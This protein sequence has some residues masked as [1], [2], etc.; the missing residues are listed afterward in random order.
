VHLRPPPALLLVVAHPLPAPIRAVV[1]RAAGAGADDAGRTSRRR[2]PP[3]RRL[4]HPC[5]PRRPCDSP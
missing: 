2:T 3:L 4:F 5:R 1:R